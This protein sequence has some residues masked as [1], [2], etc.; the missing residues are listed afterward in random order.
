MRQ[1]IPLVDFIDQFGW[2]TKNIYIFDKYVGRAAA[3]LM[4]GFRPIKIYTPIISE[5]AVQ[6]L[7]EKK[8]SYLA[9]RTV[10]HLMGI[11]S[12]ELCKWEKLSIGKDRIAFWK[13]VKREL[14]R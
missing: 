11:A 6:L 8:I 10:P 4:L 2:K 7:T 14:M 1:L 3:L 5:N 13:L 12:Q 9:E